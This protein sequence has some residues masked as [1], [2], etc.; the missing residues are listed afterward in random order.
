MLRYR[1]NKLIRLLE[2][3]D[4][5]SFNA[6]IKSDS[7]AKALKALEDSRCIDV[8]RAWGGDIV[9]VRLLSHYA[10]YQLSRRDLWLNR[11]YGFLAGVATSL[12]AHNLIVLIG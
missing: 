12:A 6:A 11:F 9:R 1:M 4:L 10:A 7:Y 5:D 8:T 2:N 3:G